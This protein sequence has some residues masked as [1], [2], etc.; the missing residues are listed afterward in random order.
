MLPLA[1][2]EGP[3]RIYWTYMPAPRS[4][5]RESSIVGRMYSSGARQASK[6]ARP[7]PPGE[8]PA[9]VSLSKESCGYALASATRGAG[10]LVTNAR[11]IPATH[12]PARIQKALVQAPVAARTWAPM[13]GPK[14][15]AEPQALK[16]QP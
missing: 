15:P 14:I 6:K 7:A 3:R 2:V 11:T 5:L 16:T 8:A 9:F 1:A 4:P 10:A 12:I 13:T